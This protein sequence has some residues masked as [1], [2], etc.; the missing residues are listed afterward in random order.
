MVKTVVAVFFLV[1][2]SFGQSSDSLFNVRYTKHAHF[3]LSASQIGEAEKL[4]Q[5]ACAVV[6]RELHTDKSLHPRFTVVL[7]AERDELHAD[8]ELWLKKWNPALF[9]QA[10]VVLSFDEMLPIDLR[11]Q[12]TKRALQYNA[13]T[14]DFS[15]LKQDH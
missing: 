10:V 9:T 11:I 4:Y 3:V 7:G 15:Q 8:A 1:S 6:Q 2:S 13:A 5:T 14:V 12:L